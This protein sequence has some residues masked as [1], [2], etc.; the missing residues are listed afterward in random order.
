VNATLRRRR[1]ERFAQRIDEADGARRHHSRSS[2]DDDLDALVDVG[3]RLTTMDFQVTMSE[4]ARSRIRAAIMKAADQ[5]GIGAG[6]KPIADLAV[7]RAAVGTIVGTAGRTGLRPVARRI[8]AR[9]AVLIG[10]GVGAIAISGI[11]TA[12]TNAKP[13]DALYGLK[14]SKERAELGMATTPSAKAQ[15]YLRFATELLGEAP[16]V[17]G[18]PAR[19]QTVLNT[20]DNDTK[21]GARLLFTAA[22]R[23]HDTSALRSVEAFYEQQNAQ[24]ESILRA[25]NAADPANNRFVKSSAVL[26]LVHQRWIDITSALKCPPLVAKP[27]DTYGP[28]V[29][30]CRTA[31]A[32]GS[33]SPNATGATSGGGH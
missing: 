27:A 8:R 21:Q 23:N 7:G 11:A 10:L 22:V 13:G 19:L 2:L 17:S 3:R 25:M 20:M 30:A 26:D 18:D 14:Q 9:G 16:A 29:A 1:I 31:P 12:A 24:V 15:L 28:S 33:A 4:S 32:F 6:A 5:E